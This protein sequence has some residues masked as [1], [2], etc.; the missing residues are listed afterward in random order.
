[1]TGLRSV[2]VGQESPCTVEPGGLDSI[3]RR[4]ILVLRLNLLEANCDGGRQVLIILLLGEICCRE[5]G[6]LNEAAK[7]VGDDIVMRARRP[8]LV[9]KG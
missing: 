9:M 5:V 7:L 4:I 1:M 2:K 6:N 3:S 8:V